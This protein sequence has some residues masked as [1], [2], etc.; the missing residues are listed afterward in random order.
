M[1][2]LKFCT[3]LENAAFEIIKTLFIRCSRMGKI[4]RRQ[5]LDSPIHIRRGAKIKIQAT[6]IQIPN[7]KSSTSQTS[8]LSLRPLGVQFW[9]ASSASANV[10]SQNWIALQK[11]SLFGA[12]T[13]T[14]TE[15]HDLRT[16]TQNLGRKPLEKQPG[17]F[18]PVWCHSKGIHSDHQ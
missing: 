8:N 7:S 12:R 18:A 16:S 14:V 1:S 6:T 5:N 3:L 17:Q 15:V 4:L 10:T 11:Y 2:H 9:R 13:S